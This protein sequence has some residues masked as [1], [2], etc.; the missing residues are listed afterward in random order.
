MGMADKTVQSW[1]DGRFG[2]LHPLLRQLHLIGGELAGPV[3][4]AYGKGL[5]GFIGRRLAKKMNIPE[6]GQ[7]TLVVRISHQPDGLH[8][9]RC[10]DGL[11]DMRSVFTPVGKIGAGYWMENSG[12][13]KMRLTVD[14]TDG[15]WYWRCLS[16]RFQGIPFPVWL[17]PH[18]KAYK[19]VE[20]GRYRFYVG[21]SLP[22]LGELLSYSGLLEAETGN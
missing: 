10:F 20:D 4:I 7:H 1:F 6:A 11:V 3:N 13:L 22:V 14:I 19:T 9:D 2:E 17:F 21:F 12:P 8:W 5:A 18:S 15:G 16:F